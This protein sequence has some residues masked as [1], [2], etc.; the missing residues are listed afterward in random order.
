MRTKNK[1]IVYL[2]IK[3]GILLP[4]LKKI[5]LNSAFGDVIFVGGQ[6]KTFDFREKIVRSFPLYDYEQ[7]W[8]I[9]CKKAQMT[10]PKEYSPQILTLNTGK[11]GKYAY[12]EE[13]LLEKY[14][15]KNHLEVFKKLYSYYEQNGIKR[16]KDGIFVVKSHGAFSKEQILMRKFNCPL[17]PS[18]SDKEIVFT[19]WES[20]E[21]IITRDLYEFGHMDSMKE[22]EFEEIIKLYPQEVQNN[23]MKYFKLSLASLEKDT[24]EYDQKYKQ[25]GKE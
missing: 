22:K 10:I 12:S 18:Y 13:E 3:S 7:D 5:K 17:N 11:E 23:L 19:D 24:K 8:F 16:N 6:I 25:G 15:G 1:Q 14:D 2:L 20:K 4:F 21:D 9:K